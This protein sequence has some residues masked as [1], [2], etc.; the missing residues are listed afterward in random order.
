MFAA[1]YEKRQ[2]AREAV[3]LICAFVGGDLACRCTNVFPPLGRN[4]D[5]SKDQVAAQ[6]RKP[7][8][9]E[10]VELLIHFVENRRDIILLGSVKAGEGG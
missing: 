2:F 10:F 8:H 6:Y 1:D 4:W 5:V 9:F 7:V 3:D